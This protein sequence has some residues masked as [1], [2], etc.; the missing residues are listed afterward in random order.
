MIDDAVVLDVEGGEVY[1][2]RSG[3][4]TSLG[5]LWIQRESSSCHSIESKFERTAPTDKTRAAPSSCK[6]A[7]IVV[8]G[9]VPARGNL[10]MATTNATESR[11]CWRER[12]LEH[13]PKVVTPMAEGEGKH[14]GPDATVESFT[15]ALHSA[16]SMGHSAAVEMLLAAGANPSCVAADGA[17]PL[18]RAARHGHYH[19][20]RMLLDAD[21]RVQMQ[22]DHLGFSALHDAAHAGHQAI[23]LLLLERRAGGWASAAGTTPLNLA[24]NGGHWQVVSELLT[25]EMWPAQNPAETLRPLQLAAIAGH[26]EVV[27][28]LLMRLKHFLT[29]SRSGSS[30]GEPGF[31]RTVLEDENRRLREDGILAD[32]PKSIDFSSFSAF[33]NLYCSL[34]FDFGE[35]ARYQT[36]SLERHRRPLAA[37]A[38][39]GFRA[40]P[41]APRTCMCETLKVKL[42]R[43]PLF[44]PG[45]F[46]GIPSWLASREGMLQVLWH[47]LNAKLIAFASD[48]RD[49]WWFGWWFANV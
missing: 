29:L 26:K 47:D 36:E 16:A 31:E 27:K 19:T 30:V 34:L 25:A 20:V 3:F 24:A 22:C 2:P 21:Q 11:R 49:G 44:R 13:I 39:G 14:L 6:K 48:P 28:L 23:V 40:M 33:S 45:R 12:C 10:D 7:P 4:W 37:I 9:E 1:K 41:A 38:G 42:A 17:T 35:L 43:Q 5:G 8:E 46:I 18:H 32:G 15:A